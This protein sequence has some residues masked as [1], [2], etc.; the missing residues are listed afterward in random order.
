VTLDT[1]IAGVTTGTAK[2]R[3]Q[4][5]IKMYPAK[6]LDQ[7]K[8]YAQWTIGGTDTRVQLKICFTFTGNGEFYKSIIIS[9]ED[10]KPLG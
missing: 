9:N 5:W 6:N 8:S 1:A 10:I 7:V 2:A 3:F 4:K